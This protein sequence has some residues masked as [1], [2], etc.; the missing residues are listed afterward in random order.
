MTTT[1]A[2]T[3]VGSS[4][5]PQPQ[6]PYSGRSAVLPLREEQTQRARGCAPAYTSRRWS[7]VTKV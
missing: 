2:S 5:N 3:G 6:T 7:T 4:A 1:G